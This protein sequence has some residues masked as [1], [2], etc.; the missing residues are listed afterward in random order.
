MTAL[1][2]D[3]SSPAIGQP[4]HLCFQTIIV[5]RLNIRRIKLDSSRYNFARTWDRLI[6][7]CTF[8]RTNF[9]Q[10]QIPESVR[11]SM[12][13]IRRHYRQ[14]NPYASSG[15]ISSAKPENLKKARLK[16]TGL[17]FSQILRVIIK[18]LFS[19]PPG[20][21]RAR[22]YRFRRAPPLRCRRVLR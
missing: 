18:N 20:S 8:R 3:Y 4:S 10:V 11:S 9:I 2:C 19:R 13:L 17:A 21:I 14:L 15:K 7:I 1:S 16:N 12:W 22:C 5:I 6:S